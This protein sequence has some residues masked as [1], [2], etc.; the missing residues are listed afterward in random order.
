[1]QYCFHNHPR[2]QADV[3]LEE[4]GPWWW[5]CSHE[6]MEGKV[7]WCKK[8]GLLSVVPLY[9]ESHM[10]VCFRSLARSV[11]V[12]CN[13]Q[14][15][16]ALRLPGS[17]DGFDC[18]DWQE[19]LNHTLL[20][21]RTLSKFV[22]GRHRNRTLPSAAI[23]QG[24]KPC[25]NW[26]TGMAASN[27]GDGDGDAGQRFESILIAPGK[28][29]YMNPNFHKVQAKVNGCFMCCVCHRWCGQWGFTGCMTIVVH[30]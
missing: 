3:V 2:N 17:A 8:G 30:R 23:K 20:V 9:C 12:N 7:K 15:W 14:C 11:L 13:V 21:V 26:E 5:I 19:R 1:M 24:L 25:I 22:R 27:A 29:K 18:C 6:D 4:G 16:H 10:S 28:M